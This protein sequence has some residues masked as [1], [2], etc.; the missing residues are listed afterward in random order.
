MVMRSPAGLTPFS[1]GERVEA[2]EKVTREVPFEGCALSR[3][4]EDESVEVE[5]LD[6][7]DGEASCGVEAGDEVKREGLQEE[8]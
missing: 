6:E 2:E 7:A 3:A 5:A 8:A 4:E 1:P